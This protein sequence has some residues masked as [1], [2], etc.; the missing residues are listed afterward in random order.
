MVVA[1]D[2]DDTRM[3]L[4]LATWA[5]LDID[6]DQG[7]TVVGCLPESCL[8]GGALPLELMVMVMRVY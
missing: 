3:T 7:C 2:G 8:H 4:I 1:G 6:G 5:V